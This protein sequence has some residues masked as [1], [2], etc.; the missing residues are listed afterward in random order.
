MDIDEG[1]VTY[2]DM[3]KWMLILI[4][5]HIYISVISIRIISVKCWHDMD[6]CEWRHWSWKISWMIFTSYDT[7]NEKY[8]YSAY[9]TT[10]KNRYV[11]LAVEY[12]ISYTCFCYNTHGVSK[13]S[14]YWLLSPVRRKPI[15]RL[16]EGLLLFKALGKSVK[17][18]QNARMGNQDKSIWKRHLRNGILF[19]TLCLVRE[20]FGPDRS[21]NGLVDAYGYVEILCSMLK[22][23]LLQLMYVSN[24]SKFGRP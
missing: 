8:V 2:A 22:T 21:P 18:T 6:H 9:R 19:R 11:R 15:I 24:T 20:V 16:K 7:R 23:W 3:N 17:K 10:K 5:T 13:I 12:C 4:H 14:Q 1:A